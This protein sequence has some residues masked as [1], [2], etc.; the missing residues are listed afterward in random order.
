ML[1]NKHGTWKAVL[2]E[3]VGRVVLLGLVIGVTA[4][5]QEERND[6]LQVPAQAVTHSAGDGSDGLDQS[7]GALGGGL[8]AR[9][10]NAFQKDLH[11][12]VKQAI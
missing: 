7:A 10:L 11:E 2:S 12:R 6:A 9:G 8:G 1:L 3:L 4:E 5:A